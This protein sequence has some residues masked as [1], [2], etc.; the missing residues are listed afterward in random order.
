MVMNRAVLVSVL[1]GAL[2]LSAG[3]TSVPKAPSVKGDNRVEVNNH[4]AVELQQCKD[5]LANTKIM[6][7]ETHRLADSSTVALS[8]M[9]ARFASLQG[10]LNSQRTSKQANAVTAHP[11]SLEQTFI[12]VPSSKVYVL[13]F[14]FNSAVVDL[15]SKSAMDLQDATKHAQLI[16][17]RGRTDGV[18]DTPGEEKI[19][20]ARAEAVENYLVSTGIDRTRIRTSY[21]GVGDRIADNSTLTGRE[22]NRRAE[23]EI[24]SY[25]PQTTVLSSKKPE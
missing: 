11:A 10:Y 1:I 6:L 22:K 12:P 5:E 24:Y 17:V 7:T 16:F 23:V 2:M 3:C 21:Q 18:T 13:H 9:A 4:T 20:K 15:T 19:A 14:P 25:M 8:Q